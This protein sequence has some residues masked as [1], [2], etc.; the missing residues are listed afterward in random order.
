[1]DEVTGF[2]GRVRETEDALDVIRRGSNVLV[3]GRAGIGK[4][5]FVQ[6][7]TTQLREQQDCLPVIHI[8]AGTTK[9]VLLE[10]ARQLHEQVGLD[11]PAQQLPPRIAVR[12]Q[13]QGWLSWED[14]VRT[15]R[16]LSVADTVDILV[17]ALHKRKLLV[18]L[19]S[20][21]VPPSQATLFAQIIDA[22]Q[23][24]AAML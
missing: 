10:T 20:L 22:S 8:P 12:A 3:T 23:V 18:V 6:H 24:V 2:I 14:L 5:C 13:R 1:M 11:I 4:S 16:R 19:E 17:P 21:E 15:V 9:Y 7:L